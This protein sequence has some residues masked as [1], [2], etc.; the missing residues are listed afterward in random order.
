M[1]S[2]FKEDSLGQDD[3][4][5]IAEKIKS[6][7]L[8]VKTV[9]EDSIARAQ[10]VNEDLNAIVAEDF[11]SA[12]NRSQGTFSGMF[13]GVPTFI[14]DTDEVQGLPLFLAVQL[15]LEKNQPKLLELLNR[16]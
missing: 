14:K 15:C 8:D 2:A 6:G 4:L 7:T 5:G 11:D 1:V 12:L 16:F 3:A 9:T 10:S 13:N